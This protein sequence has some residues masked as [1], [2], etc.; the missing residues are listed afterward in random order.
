MSNETRVF[1]RF[2]LWT[3]KDG[4]INPAGARLFKG[5]D[6]ATFPRE[7]IRNGELFFTFDAGE[8]AK[9]A[10]L[11]LAAY[12]NETEKKRN[13]KEQQGGRGKQ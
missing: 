9:V 7:C 12:I 10:A 2:Q 5:N 13:E 6:A 1:V 11:K 3:E 4:G 8:T